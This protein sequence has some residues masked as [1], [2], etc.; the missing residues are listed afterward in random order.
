MVACT[1]AA[2]AGTASQD[3]AVTAT[4][5]NGCT[6]RGPAENGPVRVACNSIVSYALHRHESHTTHWE[7][8]P[9]TDIVVV[10]VT[11]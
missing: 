7:N 11:F 3:L 10:T 9:G 1:T 2:L 6:I 5:V 8:T 4:V